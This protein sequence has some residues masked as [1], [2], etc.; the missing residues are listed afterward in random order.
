MRKTGNTRNPTAFGAKRSPVD[1][2]LIK[3]CLPLA[4][5]QSIY[6]PRTEVMILLGNSV[7]Q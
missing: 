7:E 6:L 5:S 2:S 3:I 4:N 1:E